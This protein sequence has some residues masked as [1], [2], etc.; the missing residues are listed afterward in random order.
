M[1]AVI[2]VDLYGCAC[3]MDLIINVAVKHNLKVAEGAYIRRG[4]G[5][6]NDNRTC[7]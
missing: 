6:N 7:K 3:G 1:R 5:K 4:I 2:P